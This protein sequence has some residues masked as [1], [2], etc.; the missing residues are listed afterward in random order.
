VKK[1]RQAIRDYRIHPDRSGLQGTDFVEI[2]TGRNSDSFGGTSSL[3]I[4]KDSFLV[5]DGIIRRHYK[6]YDHYEMKNISRTTGRKIVAS[7]RE[8]AGIVSACAG[9]EILKAV[10][11]E[12]DSSPRTVNEFIRNKG[13][14]SKMLSAVADYLEAAY[15]D[16]EWV[17]IDTDQSA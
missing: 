5:I 1:R 7:L 13:L 11:Y 12:I 9:K 2:S 8:A 16:N 15:E 6:K 4:G 17:C 3:F 14:I 10:G